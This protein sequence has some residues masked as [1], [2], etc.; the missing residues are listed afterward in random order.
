MAKNRQEYR[1]RI[2]H[3]HGGI[4]VNFCKKPGCS[5]FGMPARVNIKGLHLPPIVNEKTGK[6]HRDHY[7]VSEDKLVC[8]DCRSEMPM[9][10]NKAIHEELTRMGD[11]LVPKPMPVPSRSGSETRRARICK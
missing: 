1:Q 5:N 10:S 9:K 6:K 4:Q 2:P 8:H 11:Y 7:T 3:E